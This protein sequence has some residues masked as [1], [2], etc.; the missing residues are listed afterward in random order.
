MLTTKPEFP[1]RRAVS[2]ILHPGL[3]VRGAGLHV[4]VGAVPGER[5]VLPGG[6]EDGERCAGGAA[7]GEIW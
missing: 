6:A 7:R 2:H 4:A 1:L 3:R 5:V